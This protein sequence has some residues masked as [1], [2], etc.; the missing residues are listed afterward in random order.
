MKKTLCQG[1][2]FLVLLTY[3]TTASAFNPI[4]PVQSIFSDQIQNVLSGGLPAS[5]I[6]SPTPIECQSQQASTL[7][8]SSA[9]NFFPSTSLGTQNVAQAGIGGLG[10]T[11]NEI[12]S[13]F[14]DMVSG[15]IDDFNISNV[16]NVHQIF[17]Q[18]MS[19]DLPPETIIANA[20]ENNLP[21]SYSQRKDFAE[22]LAKKT[23][24]TILQVSIKNLHLE[25]R[26]FFL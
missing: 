21:N 13:F 18:I 10:G 17:N 25:L 7:S 23:I 12:A 3:P 22:T 9:F 4:A 6:K 24:T 2:S 5:V 26:D 20:I 19:G 1:I 14:T 16:V 8:P 11:L 15:L